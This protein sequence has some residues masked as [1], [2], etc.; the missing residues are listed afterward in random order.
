MLHPSL[1]SPLRGM[2]CPSSMF[3]RGVYYQIALRPTPQPSKCR[4]KVF[5]PVLRLARCFPRSACT[6]ENGRQTQQ[7]GKG[8]IEANVTHS[9]HRRSHSLDESCCWA[10]SLSGLGIMR[11]TTR[12]LSAGF[13]LRVYGLN[14]LLYTDTLRY[15]YTCAS[16][17]CNDPSSIQSGV[18]RARALLRPPG[19]C[20]RPYP[21][22][23]SLGGLF[24]ARHR[25]SMPS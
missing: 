18:L 10:S 1:S 22:L 4:A 24:V 12:D 23:W 15:F 13:P 8:G 5:P 21:I 3:P 14:V 7:E 9:I 2:T 6:P 11:Q 25:A 19:S 17:L 20:D 16:I